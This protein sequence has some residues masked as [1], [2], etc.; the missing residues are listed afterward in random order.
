MGSILGIA[1][2][3]NESRRK[4]LLYVGIQGVFWFVVGMIGLQTLGGIDPSTIDL[5]TTEALL[6]DTYRQYGQLG[7]SFLYF[8]L[9]LCLFDYISPKTQ[10]RRTKFFSVVTPIRYDFCHSVC[11]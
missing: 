4:I 3:R 1:L 11:F 9:A 2:A 7:I 5:N 10:A 8:F 6:E